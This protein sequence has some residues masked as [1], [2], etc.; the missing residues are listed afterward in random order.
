MVELRIPARYTWGPPLGK[1]G[2]FRRRRMSLRLGT[3]VSFIA[4]MDLGEN[5]TLPV[6][7]RL[8]ITSSESYLIVVLFQLI[9]V[10][11]RGVPP[12]ASV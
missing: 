6:L 3:S 2:S 11:V 12:M 1:G 10:S 7:R 4:A 9:A 5:D 8:D